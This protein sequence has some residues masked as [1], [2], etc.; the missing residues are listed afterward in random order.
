MDNIYATRVWLRKILM[1][2]PEWIPPVPTPYGL[3]IRLNRE[4]EKINTL[5]DPSGKTLSQITNV[6][7]P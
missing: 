2:L 4:G 7:A 1:H 6:V 5:H 3:V